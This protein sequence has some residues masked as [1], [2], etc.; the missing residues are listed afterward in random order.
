M[1]LDTHAHKQT[2]MHLDTHAHKQTHTYIIPISEHCFLV[3]KKERGIQIEYLVEVLQM[4]DVPSQ[5]CPAT[6]E[7]K[8]CCWSLQDR[9]RRHSY[10][11]ISLWT[12]VLFFFPLL[13]WKWDKT[14]KLEAKPNSLN[15]VGTTD[16]KKRRGPFLVVWQNKSIFMAQLL[17]GAVG[18]ECQDVHCISFMQ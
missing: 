5:I 12:A 1:H 13:S 2:H 7:E 14:V 11:V 17:D 3:L 16:D 10:S 8:A 6:T 9:L 4:T 18:E 15:V